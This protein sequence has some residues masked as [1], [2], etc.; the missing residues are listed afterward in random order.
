MPTVTCHYSRKVSDADYGNEE[1]SASVTI[2]VTQ[3][4][5]YDE[6]VAD[7]IAQWHPRLHDAVRQQLHR[8]LNP[9]VARAVETPTEGALRE[10]REGNHR[11]LMAAFRHL[12]GERRASAYYRQQLEAAEKLAASAPTSED[13]YDEPSRADLPQLRANQE[14]TLAKLAVAEQAFD[15]LRSHCAAE[16]VYLPPHVF[17]ENPDDSPF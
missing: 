13:P 12:Q 4:A 11:R 1:A 6:A 15:E 9:S 2:D 16:G 14:A 17:H 10:E 8:S 7:L 3:E 5:F